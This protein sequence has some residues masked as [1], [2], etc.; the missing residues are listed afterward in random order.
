MLLWNMFLIF[1]AKF[2]LTMY[3]ISVARLQIPMMSGFAI[4]K[5]KIQK[6]TFQTAILDLYRSFKLGDKS[7]YKRNC[8]I[9]IQLLRF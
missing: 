8:S 6:A 9:Y 7:L 5:Y 3:S 1:L 4:T 2:T